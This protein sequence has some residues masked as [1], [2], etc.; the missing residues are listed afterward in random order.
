M[1]ESMDE[2]KCEAL[3]TAAE[4][5]SLSKAAKLL[6]YTQPGI[7]RMI[8]SLERELG[9]PLL[10]RTKRGVALT[11]NGEAVFPYLKDTLRAARLA[12]ETGESIRGL[13]SGTLII[14]CYYSVSSMILPPVLKR[15]GTD[16]PQVRIVLKE[17]TNAD[18]AKA[19]EDRT[20]DLSLAAP[21]PPAVECDHIPILKDEL[22]AWLPPNHP[23]AKAPSFPIQELGSFP[24]IITEPGQDTDIDRLL[25]RYHIHPDIHFAT[26]D[27]YSTYRMVEAGLGIS[28]NQ[29]LFARG[30][31]GKV[32]TVPFDPP[33]YIH[34]GIS[35]PSLKEASPAAKKFIQYVAEEYGVGNV[36]IPIRR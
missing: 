3:V 36:N 27:A 24:F 2:I 26:K 6:G 16:Y 15:F 9:F 20:I 19:L 17:G 7:S 10:V 18:L 33:Q 34:L 8:H 13:L 12:H 30:W 1:E 32:A 11:P 5:G 22:V 4:Q 14:G 29:S 23:L 35:I 21:P 31:K 25:S 28:F